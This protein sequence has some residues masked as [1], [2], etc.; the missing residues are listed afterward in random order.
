MGRLWRL[1]ASNRRRRGQSVLADRSTRYR[2]KP[3][4][5]FRSPWVAASVVVGLIVV[6]GVVLVIPVWATD[7]PT[8][9]MSCKAT[10]A[11]GV[12]WKTSV[13]AKVSCTA[14]HVPPGLVNAVKWRAREWL[15]V[16]AQYLNVPRAATVGQRPT[17]ANCLQC[18][19][20][21]V[22]PDQFGNIRFSH[23][24]HANLRNLTC[25]D[26]HAQSTH[27]AMGTTTTVPMQ[28]CGMCHGAQI[29]SSDCSFC[30]VTS[31]PKTTHPK[32]W[33]E[34]HGVAALANEQ[35]CLRC[36]HNP[37]QFCDACHAQP[38]LDHF[39]GTW[40]YTHGAVEKKNPLSCTGCH[41]KTFCA[42]CHTVSHP[43]NWVAIH[44]PVAAR[45]GAAC[46]VCHQQAMCDAC[47]TKR[48]VTP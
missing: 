3:R 42:Q 9:C 36:H 16:W 30:H 18:H 20:L 37:K 12:E 31:P 4:E 43:S 8:Y 44:G 23:E 26:C 38:P 29:S 45:S 21:S 46:L 48:G 34:T 1:L 17:N 5:W 24:V 39:S 19:T 15:N 11:A 33:I 10:K 6:L 25:A 2:P 22:L 32:N 47:H 7:T 27:A 41:T 28:E 13:H 14:C 40:R 35:A